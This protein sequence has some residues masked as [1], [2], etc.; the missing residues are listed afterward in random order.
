M[1][2]AQS[3]N[4]ELHRAALR[5]EERSE[6]SGYAC[7]FLLCHPDTECRDFPTMYSG[8][9]LK[10]S[11]ASLSREEQVRVCNSVHSQLDRHPEKPKYAES[12]PRWSRAGQMSVMRSNCKHLPPSCFDD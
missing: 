7:Q 6:A 4:K 10:N 8:T 9:I 12:D 3:V 5:M 11:D 1:G 2:S